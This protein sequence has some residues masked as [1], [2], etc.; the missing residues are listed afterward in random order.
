MI[1]REIETYEI[2]DE[3]RDIPN[4]KSDVGDMPKE[5]LKIHHQKYNRNFKKCTNRCVEKVGFQSLLKRII[6][7]SI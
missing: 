2:G 7:I 1:F 6:V 4:K 5:T 3:I